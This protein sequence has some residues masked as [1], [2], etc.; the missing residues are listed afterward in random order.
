MRHQTRLSTSAGDAKEDRTCLD[1]MQRGFFFL[2]LNE[3][4]LDVIKVINLFTIG[5][6]K[7]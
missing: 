6:D 5:N 4:I 3:A 2:F 7:A 1:K